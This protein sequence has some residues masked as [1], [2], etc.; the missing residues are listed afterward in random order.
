M[1]AVQDCIGGATVW[2]FAALKFCI[3][4][5]G[6]ILALFV[7]KERKR[8]ALI[9]ATCVFFATLVPLMI[10]TLFHM[11]GYIRDTAPWTFKYGSNEELPWD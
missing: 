3:A 9:A 5:A 6:F 10:H 8:P 4:A 11:V 1:E 2:D 7:P